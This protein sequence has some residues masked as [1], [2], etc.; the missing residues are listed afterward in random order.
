MHLAHSPAIH[1]CYVKP[2]NND[3]VGKVVEE[4]KFKIRLG[5]YF[6]HRCCFGN[7]FMIKFTVFSFKAK[8]GC[9]IC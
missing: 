1:I 7:L 9:E 4:V 5:G 6:F 8:L 2:L 3:E